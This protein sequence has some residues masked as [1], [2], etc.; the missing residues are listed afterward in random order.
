[1]FDFSKRKIIPVTLPYQTL[2][3][4]NWK[5]REMKTYPMPN[6]VESDE[7]DNDPIVLVFGGKSTNF[8]VLR[9]EREWSSDLSASFHFSFSAKFMACWKVGMSGVP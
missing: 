9:V 1:M 3:L 6:L 8:Q 5:V 7:E 2:A 4:W